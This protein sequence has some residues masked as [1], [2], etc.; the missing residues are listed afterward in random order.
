MQVDRLLMNRIQ[1]DE[2]IATQQEIHRR[3]ETG[4]TAKRNQESAIRNQ[5]IETGVFGF[6]SIDL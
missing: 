4:I 2:V 1:N 3:M 5:K 6:D